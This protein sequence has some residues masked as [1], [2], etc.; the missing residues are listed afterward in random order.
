MPRTTTATTHWPISSQ[1]AAA[2][3]GSPL[4]D[5]GMSSVPATTG[6]T[7]D[8]ILGA[9]KAAVVGGTLPQVSWVVTDQI[10]SEH[11]I[12]PPV[13]GERFVSGLLQA[14]AADANTFN[15]TVVFLNYDENDGFFDHV[16]PPSPAAGTTGEF[17]N[18]TPVGLGFRVPMIAISPW[19][20]G[21]WVD[22]EVF[23]HTSVIRFMETWSAAVGKPELPGH[24]RL[25]ALGLRKSD[26]GFRL[27]EPCF[28]AALAAHAGRRD[29]RLDMHLQ[30][31]S[32]AA[33]QRAAATGVRHQAGQSPAVPDKCLGFLM[34]VRRQQPHPG[35]HR[36]LEREPAGHQTGPF[37]RLRQRFP[38]RR[39]VAIHR[40]GVRS[41]HRSERLDHR[42]LQLRPQFRQWLL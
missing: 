21:G 19:T 3:A 42:L 31:Q 26:L 7:P 22:S 40:A 28:R 16:P 13:N 17:V 1:F 27:R 10:T 14:L 41:G 6:K 8:D 5:N 9:I 25:A 32:V 15:S 33:K 34:D 2:K 24:Q 30:T 39:P 35:E 11:P 18:G 4:Y 12:G 36:P 20:R 38:Y 37:R 29:R 23:D